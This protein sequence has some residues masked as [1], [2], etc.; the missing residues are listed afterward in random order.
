[1][2]AMVK[3][4]NAKRMASLSRNR[5]APT[6]I[7]LFAGAGGMSCAFERSGFET[8]SAIDKDA[9]CVATLRATQ[10]ARVRISK[11]GRRYLDGSRLLEADISDIRRADL[12]P[13]GAGTDWRPDL[14]AGGPPCQPFSSAGSGLALDDPR[15]QLFTHFVRLAHELRP[16]IVLFENVAGLV[17]AKSRDGGPGGVLRLIQRRFEEAG[18]ACRFELL[19][20][21]DFGAPQRRVR[22][23]MIA[24]CDQALPE[25]PVGTHAACGA[26]GRRLWMSLRRCL[27]SLPEPSPLDIVRPKG[28]RTA[29]LSAL[30]PGTGLKSTGIVEANRPSGHWGYRQDCFLADLNSPS[31]T[32]RAASTPDWIQ[33]PDGLRQLTWR[34]CAALQGFPKGWVFQGGHTSRFRQIGNAV[35]GHIGEALAQVLRRAL[36]RAEVEHPTSAPWPPSFHK[37]VRYT[38]MEARVNGGHREAAR[39]LRSKGAEAARAAV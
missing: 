5:A 4:F 38:A 31:R 19:N 12:V 15:G 30:T 26:G 24:T 37:R 36:H 1:M 32:I 39:A 27:K 2:A 35:Q 13:V 14:L 21:A 17:T 22:L 8:V 6:L 20:A 34:E 11:S 25:F 9:D 29:E 7:D 18:Y 16:R 33:S 28:R 23:Y 3:K 10:Q